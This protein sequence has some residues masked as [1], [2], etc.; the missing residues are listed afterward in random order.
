MAVLSRCAPVPRLAEALC[1]R[2]STQCKLRLLQ[3]CV[4]TTS[5][6]ISNSIGQCPAPSSTEAW[7]RLA[8]L[9]AGNILI[10]ALA[11]ELA[12][13]L[14]REWLMGATGAESALCHARQRG[15]AP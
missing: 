13:R 11:T 6:H 5:S 3:V 4:W 1:W 7:T 9:G 8:P 12:I 2:D 14:Q 10:V 15:N